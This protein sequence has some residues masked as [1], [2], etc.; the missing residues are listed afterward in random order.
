MFTF[1]KQILK[2]CSLPVKG[3]KAD[4]ACCLKRRGP[5]QGGAFG[6]GLL[7]QD[8]GIGETE[9]KWAGQRV[10]KETRRG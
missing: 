10:L 6:G 2:M 1:E 8:L 5:G 9:L 3:K 7:S 4:V